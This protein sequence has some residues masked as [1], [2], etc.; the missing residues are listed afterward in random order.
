MYTIPEQ[1]LGLLGWQGIVPCKRLKMANKL[2]D[3]TISKLLKINEIF[4]KLE[5][6]K[7]ADLVAPT[8]SDSVLGGI[9][10]A[11]ILKLFLKKTSSSLISGIEE[12]VDIKS[13]VVGGLT[14]DPGILGGFFQRVANVEL[15]FLVESGFG[16]GFLLGLLQMLQWMVFPANWTLVVGMKHF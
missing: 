13:I 11:S 14:N 6:T 2:V 12:V 9:V 1:P 16:F 3:V 4:G 7:I 5:P 8:L 15:K 10:P